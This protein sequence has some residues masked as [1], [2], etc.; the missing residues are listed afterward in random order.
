M[1]EIKMC[2]QLLHIA[3]ATGALAG[4]IPA[5]SL[6]DQVNFKSGSVG[7][8][9]LNGVSV[10]SGYSTSASPAGFGQTAAAGAQLGASFDYGANASFGWQHHRQG[11]DLSVM[12]SL[13]YSGLSRYSE[14]NGL[15]H[16]LS[17][18][19]NRRLGTKWTVNLT[20][21]AQDT[22]LAEF[23]YQPSAL[24]VRSQLPGTIDDLA[25]A[26]SIGQF[27]NTQI[28]SMFTGATMLE[29]PTSSLLLGT[30][31]LSY[32]ANVGL[33]Y[34]PTQR[35]SFHFASFSGGGQSQRGGQSGIPPQ[36]LVLPRSLDLS[37]GMG[38]SYALSPRTQVGTDLEENRVNNRYQN[39][40][41]TSAT[42]SIARKMGLRWF[43][44]VNGGGS[45]T[46]TV[47]AT[48]ATPASRQVIGGGSI[49]FRTYTQTLTASYNRS[50]SDTYGIAVGTITSATGSWNRR[51]PGSSWSIF[52]S[53][54]QSQIRN[55]GF[56]SISGWQA[57]GGIAESLNARTSLS[58]QYVYFTSAGN[59]SGQLNNFAVHSV[60]VSLGWTP[61]PVQRH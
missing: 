19:V 26:F 21:V 30:R 52:A 10:Y 31:V 22:T 44:S 17:I 50:G 38:F 28:A 36:R 8:F 16:S 5:Q 6:T 15:S 29:S 51:R 54:G 27:S 39:V 13:T 59:Y 1:G 9:Q 14:L 56:A 43:L 58:A 32:S 47:Q 48:Y 4:I 25:A 33:N 40:Y 34:T 42:V 57:S 46:Q 35:L 49:G 45:I 7:G 61:Q 18:G 11:T 20:G 3:I 12:Y 24:S 55:A 37:G 23:M 2:R 41:T 60:R 53:G